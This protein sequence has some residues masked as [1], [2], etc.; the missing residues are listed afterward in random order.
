MKV[1]I[2]VDAELKISDMEGKRKT[3]LVLKDKDEPEKTVEIDISGMQLSMIRD[4]KHSMFEWI[5]K[6]TLMAN[7]IGMGE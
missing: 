1:G 7:C 2:N 6:L 3:Y 5:E 4:G